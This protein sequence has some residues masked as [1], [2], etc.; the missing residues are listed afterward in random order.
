MRIVR[1]LVLQPHSRSHFFVEDNHVEKRMNFTR[2]RSRVET[3]I[4]SDLWSVEAVGTQEEDEDAPSVVTRFSTL[5]P[6]HVIY[7]QHTR[8][9]VFQSC[10]F[11]NFLRI[12]MSEEPQNCIRMFNFCGRPMC[13]HSIKNII[14]M[15]GICQQTDINYIRHN[16]IFLSIF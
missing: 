13:H 5:E 14:E 7:A 16:H 1:R 6:R 3:Y 10:T 4:K 8:G 2:A 11:T 12:L 15:T 9:V